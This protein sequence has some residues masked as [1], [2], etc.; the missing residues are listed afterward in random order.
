MKKNIQAHPFH[1]VE[2]SPWPLASSLALLITTISAVMYFNNYA[3]G[4]L[5]LTLGLISTVLSMSLWFRDIII[6]AR[7]TLVAS[8]NMAICW[9]TLRALS[10]N[11]FKEVVKILKIEQSAGNQIT[12]IG[13]GILRDYTPSIIKFSDSIDNNKITK[14][15]LE[16]SIVISD[17]D[18]GAYLA[19]LTEGD[20]SISIDNPKIERRIVNPAFIFTFDKNNLFLYEYLKSRIGSGSIYNQNS[21]TMRYVIRDIKGVIKLTELMNGYFRTPKIETFHKLILN[22]NTTRS[23]NI[24]LLPLNTS[25]INND[26][27]FAG[28]CE[29]D[30]YFRIV[31]RYNHSLKPELNPKISCRFT[32]E[33]RQIDKPTGQSCKPFMSMLADYFEVSLLSKTVNNEKY[34]SSVNSYYFSVESLLKIKKVENYFEKYPLMGV[35]GLDLKDFIT[36]YHMILNKEHLTKE[37]KDKL[38]LIVAN[39]NKNRK[40]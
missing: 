25:P 40:L 37:G 29:A 39:M 9:K 35:K 11:L 24:P 3:N 10:T 26:A 30:G 32:I 12:L 19:G 1:L 21:N 4:G 28:F 17:A 36:G 6:E 15:R 13:N 23:L 38:I 18:L 5:L 8:L 27:W 7:T 14:S 33:Q 16:E 31:L 22:L 20:G 2:P 34:I